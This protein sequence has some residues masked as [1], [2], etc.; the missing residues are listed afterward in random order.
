[1]IGALLIGEPLT[2]KKAHHNASKELV[3]AVG[4]VAGLKKQYD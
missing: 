1:M 4:F 3:H 2:N